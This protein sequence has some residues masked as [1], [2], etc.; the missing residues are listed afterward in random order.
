MAVP[1]KLQFNKDLL[2]KKNFNPDIIMGVK[3]A[4]QY[5]GYFGKFSNQN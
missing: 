1:D 3:V 5:L 4:I 2:N